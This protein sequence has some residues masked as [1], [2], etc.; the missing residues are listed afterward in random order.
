[1]SSNS[2]PEDI[3]LD[4]IENNRIEI[5]DCLYGSFFPKIRT[6]FVSNSSSA[7]FV[8]AAKFLTDEQK[9]LLLFIDDSKKEKKHIKEFTGRDIFPSENNYPRNEEYHQKYK[10]MLKELDFSDSWTT[11]FSERHNTIDG[12][13]YMDNGFLKL[14]ME[15]IGIDTDKVEFTDQH[16]TIKAT[17]PDA[18]TFF[19]DEHKKWFDGLTEKDYKFFESMGDEPPTRIS[20]YEKETDED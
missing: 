6:G 17:H 9:E 2:L 13:T 16:D 19:I 15:N 10:Q 14:L 12:G 20:I 1:M 5:K 7:S 18:I 4:M 11:Y 3:T 8:V